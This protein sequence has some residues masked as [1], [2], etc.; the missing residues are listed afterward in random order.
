MKITI[1]LIEEFLQNYYK[2]I[3]TQKNIFI[4]LNNIRIKTNHTHEDILEYLYEMKNKKSRQ[5]YLSI[6]NNYKNWIQNDKHKI[7]EKII[8]D[9]CF[10]EINTKYLYR[11]KNKKFCSLYLDKLFDI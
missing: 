11:H 1:E 7:N 2:N 6:Y 9:D 10:I 3:Y 5:N 4:K 8:C